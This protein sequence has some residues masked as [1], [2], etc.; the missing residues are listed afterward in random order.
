MVFYQLV[1][2]GDSWYTNC[3]Y[4]PLHWVEASVMYVAGG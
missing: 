4:Y 1:F 2:Y 3:L